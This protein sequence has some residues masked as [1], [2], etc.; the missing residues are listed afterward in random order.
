M[1]FTQVPRL[2]Q[3]SG[4][5][6]PLRCKQLTADL[7]CLSAR[8]GGPKGRN[9]W[10]PGQR[11]HLMDPRLALNLQHSPECP[12]CPASTPRVTGFCHHTPFLQ[13]G[14]RTQGSYSLTSVLLFNF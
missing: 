10:V 6:Q 2:T 9:K 11:R 12:D 3:N 8:S 13:A 14:D 7:L 1:P 4:L 5:S